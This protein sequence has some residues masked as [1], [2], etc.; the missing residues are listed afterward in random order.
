MS[1]PQTDHA[2]AAVTIPVNASKGSVA[3]LQN[4]R[5]DGF[6][7]Y[8]KTRSIIVFNRMLSGNIDLKDLLTLE[9][10]AL[11]KGVGIAGRGDRR[12]R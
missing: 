9:F 3:K 8:R 4:G 10:N 7:A 12:W 6:R 11:S 2:A 5:A 1:P